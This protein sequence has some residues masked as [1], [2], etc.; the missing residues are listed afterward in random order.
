M[1]FAYVKTAPLLY[2]LSLAF[3]QRLARNL[4]KIFAISGRILPIKCSRIGQTH[5]VAKIIIQNGL[6]RQ[7]NPSQINFFLIE[8]VRPSGL[9]RLQKTLG[10]PKPLIPPWALK[11]I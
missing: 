5:E 2:L 7:Q 11:V 9:E 3:A 1:L 8:K 4:A 6:H 10:N